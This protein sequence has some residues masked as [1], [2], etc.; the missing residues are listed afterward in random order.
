MSPDPYLG[1]MDLANPQSF[2]RYSYVGNSPLSFTDPS[3]L[4]SCGNCQSSD[5]GGGS[6]GVIE[7]IATLGVNLLIGEVEKRF[8]HPSFHG[9]MKP[10]PS[11]PES[12]QASDDLDWDN[13]LNDHLGLPAGGHLPGGGIGGLFGLPSGCEFGACGFQQGDNPYT[14]HAS[15]D[16]IFELFGW[17]VWYFNSLTDKN[18]R[19]FGTHYCGPGGGGSVGPGLDS[20]CAA[21]DACYKDAGVGVWDNWNLNLSPAKQAAISGCNQNLCNAVRSLKGGGAWAVNQTFTNAWGV[22]TCH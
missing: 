7:V 22:Y 19:L 14:K 6:G 2:N 15:L 10:R 5:S 4:L 13:A 16:N 11:D 21:H 1:S 9:S 12:T 20:A 18:T 3:G 8:S 17:Q